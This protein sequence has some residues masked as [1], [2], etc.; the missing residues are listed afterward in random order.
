[1]AT[2]TTVTVYDGDQPLDDLILID[3]PGTV[4]D[5]VRSFRREGWTMIRYH[6]DHADLVRHNSRARVRPV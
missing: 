5:A 2:Q 3:L 6:D 1:M 4:D